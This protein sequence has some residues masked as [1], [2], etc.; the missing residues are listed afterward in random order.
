MII[1]EDEVVESDAVRTN[2]AANHVGGDEGPE[3]IADD[4]VGVGVNVNLDDDV[5]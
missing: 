1:V 3:G 2:D 5:D 4:D